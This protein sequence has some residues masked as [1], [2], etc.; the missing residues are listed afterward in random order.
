[1]GKL[2]MYLPP[3]APDYSGV[4]SALFELGGLVV[5]HDG[6]GCTGNYTGYD[7]PR[8]YG[9]KSAVF[10]SGL[11]EMD[12]VLGLDDR[13][14]HK[15]KKACEDVPASFVAVMGSPAPM[16]IG[17]DMHGIASELEEQLGIPC[18][19]L[20]TSGMHLYNKGIGM[21]ENSIA[22]RFV[23]KPLCKREKGVNILGMTPLDFSL[24]RNSDDLKELLTSWGYDLVACFG[25]GTSL[26]SIS[27]AAEAQ[28]NV[29]VSAG[30]MALAKFMEQKYQI[31]YVAGI[32]MGI[33]G[34]E[35]LK[36]ALAET[37]KDKQSRVLGK[38]EGETE[39]QADAGKKILFLGEQLQ[40]NSFRA[41]Y[42]RKH[43]R[44]NIQVGCIFGKDKKLAAPADLELPDEGMVMDLLSAEDYDMIIAD[45]LFE[46]LIP[47][48]KQEKTKFVKFPHISVSS[49][50]YWDRA[51]V[52]YG[53][54]AEALL[55]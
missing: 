7:E 18:F 15:I 29:V 13:L 40:G 55:G 33:S 34:G 11:R 48:E 5:I 24:N 6:G 35:C 9:S 44:A 41:A 43:G 45:P 8:W 36:E 14:I 25:M 53:D 1:M 37:M 12:A 10:C 52:F 22:K 31:P 19:G 46:E 3:F 4:C 16:L 26:G 51:P 20:D 54:E 30:G 47:A 2:R 28:V 38:N 32:A 21:A 39:L 23:K 27:Q 17:S 49:K 50:L 42:E